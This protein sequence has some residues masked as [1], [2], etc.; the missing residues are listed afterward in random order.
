M[1][2]AIDIKTPQTYGIK[3]NEYRT[4]LEDKR[5]NFLNLVQPE[6]VN[7]MN[8]DPF[9]HESSV[10]LFTDFTIW[11]TLSSKVSKQKRIVYNVLAMFGDVG[12][13]NDFI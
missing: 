12:G 6:T 11:I 1:Q 9:F 8:F 3:L 5:F 4:E 13:L 10:E 7:F 2:V